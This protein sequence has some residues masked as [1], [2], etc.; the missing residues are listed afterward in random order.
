[1]SFIG[2]YSNIGFYAL[3]C[4]GLATILLLLT[5]TL[6]KV[7]PE[8]TLK[9]LG[10]SLLKIK[11]L[12]KLIRTLLYQS[13]IFIY[14]FGL[15]VVGF[16]T[17]AI[18]FGVSPLIIQGF[19]KVVRFCFLAYRA[20]DLF[21]AFQLLKQGPKANLFSFNKITIV[22]IIKTCFFT[23]YFLLFLGTGDWASLVAYCRIKFWGP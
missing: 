3:V 16:N 2:E 5:Y 10:D 11:N 23:L 21:Q 20:Y 9:R 7:L 14:L 6:K 13:L 12:M 18:D 8:T 17:I 22:F 19:W 4:A 1:M 15:F